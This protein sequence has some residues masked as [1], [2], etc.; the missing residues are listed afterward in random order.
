MAK[1]RKSMAA[2]PI[3][4]D[5][6][7]DIYRGQLFIFL[8]DA[9]LAFCSD[10]S[11]ELTAEE[12][13][14][15]NKMCAGNWNMSLPGKKSFTASA[16][17]LLTRLEGAMSFDTLLKKF[18]AGETLSFFFGDAKVS[19]ETETGG[20][21]DKDT[22]KPNYTGRIMVTSLSLKSTNGQIASSSASFKGVGALTPVE[23][24]T[25]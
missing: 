2:T 16:E 9:P 13:D 24:V 8:D 17:S 15:S 21:F 22:A 1:L 20:K 5:S 12:V 23:P 18:I 4:H 10:C 7:K 3:K 6:D 19:E 11:L 14:T 25:V